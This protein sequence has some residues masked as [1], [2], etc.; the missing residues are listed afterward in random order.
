MD[1]TQLIDTL[2][3]E[4]RGPLAKSNGEVLGE[5]ALLLAW[6]KIDREQGPLVSLVADGAM[7][8]R[9]AYIKVTEGLMAAGKPDQARL[10]KASKLPQML[11]DHSAQNIAK[12]LLGASDTDAFS[13][14]DELYRQAAEVPPGRYGAII[15]SEELTSLMYQLGTPDA[16]A[17]YAP[18]P[19]S[20]RIA[21]RH[22]R[23]GRPSTTAIPQVDSLLGA[24]AILAG[25]DLQP[26]DPIRSSANDEGAVLKQ[27][28]ILQMVPPLGERIERTA[29]VK[30][31]VI[32]RNAEALAIEHGLA[33][34][35][36]RMLVLVSQGLLF[37]GAGD[38]DL[39]VSLI[40]SGLLDAVIQLPQGIIAPSTNISTAILV[41][42]VS[43]DRKAP[44]LFYDASRSDTAKP[45]RG[46]RPKFEDWQKVADDVLAKVSGGHAKLVTAARIREARFDLSVSRYVRGP[47][48][49]KIFSLPNTKPLSD[50]VKL[51]RAQPLKEEDADTGDI[52]KVVGGKDIGDD[53]M[54]M[55]PERQMRL[56]GRARDR[57][58]LQLLESGDILIS[59]KGTIGLVGLVGDEHEENWVA[60]QIFQV[61]RLNKNAPIRSPIYLFR[62]LS[63][64]LVQ[65]YLEEQVTGTALAV[66]K[67]TDIKDLPVPVPSLEEEDR[68]LQ[69]HAKIAEGYQRIKD[70]E[71]EI[72][73]LKLLTLDNWS[74]ED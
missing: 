46:K 37:R 60:N 28:P 7:G 11:S 43:R 20:L 29:G 73:A 2:S 40:D 58:E 55:P 57:A 10:Y 71:G 61:I 19:A 54:V 53:G 31:K 33:R 59:T 14:T 72:T 64:P 24:I 39:R 32:K 34:C 52:F 38:Y 4:L 50:L 51:I 26:G 25:L 69:V 16:G 18:F 63:S 66:M 13:L 41:I 1:A 62:Y 65:A 3:K 74:A 42:D 67:T 6:N 70:V 9:E 44:V 17:M 45:E 23:E 56:S 49:K 68:V 35:S 8:L 48:T 22:A 30:G 21:V 36:G 27:F 12:L 5:V 47:A 15:L